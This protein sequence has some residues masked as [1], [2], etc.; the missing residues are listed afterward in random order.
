MNAEFENLLRLLEST[1]VANVRFGFQLAHNYEAEVE[2]H[3][4]GSRQDFQ[5]YL[6]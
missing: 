6:F 4:G 1:D 3:F 5:A 2:A